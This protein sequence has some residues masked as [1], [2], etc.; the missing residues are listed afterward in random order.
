MS[1]AT[2]PAAKPKKA[3]RTRRQILETALRLFR[4]RGYEGTTMRAIAEEAG[5][6]LG[7]AY[8]YFKSKEHLIQAY[9]ERS[10]ADHVAACTEI[11]EREK[12]LGRRLAGVL[13][14]KIATSESYHRFAGQLF[15]TAADPNSPLS[16][17]SPESSPVRREATELLAQVVDGSELKVPAKLVEELPHL[18]WLYLMGIILFWIHDDSEG[19]A[20]TYRLIDRTVDVVARLLRIASLPPLRPLVRGAVDISRELRDSLDPGNKAHLQNEAAR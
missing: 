7:N 5:V 6:S 3:E 2:T 13:R 14:A 4:E 18:L 9:Y 10:H 11:L 16:P 17:F 19:C 15:K 12:K 8:Y 1:E 20:R